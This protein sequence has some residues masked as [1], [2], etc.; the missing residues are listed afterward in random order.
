MNEFAQSQREHKSDTIRTSPR[1]ESNAMARRD[2]QDGLSNQI[3]Q[4]RAQTYPVFPGRCSFGGACHTCP[5][6]VQAKLTINEPGDKYEQEADRVADQ[7]MRMPDPGEGSVVSH[8]SPMIQRTCASCEEELQRQVEPEEEEE[9]LQTKPLADQITPLVQRQVEPEEEEEEPIQTKAAPKRTPTVT[10]DIQAQ[11]N[12]FRGRGRPLSA[13]TRAFFDQR[14]GRDFSHVRIHDDEQAAITTR[15]IQARAFTLGHNVVFG[16]GQYAPENVAGRRLLAHELAHVVQQRNRISGKTAQNSGQI[17][18]QASQPII[19]RN[20]SWTSLPKAARKTL[21]HSFKTRRAKPEEWIWW[22]GATACQCFNRLRSDRQSA[23]QSV[24]NALTAEGMWPEVLRVKDFWPRP[25]RGIKFVADSSKRL[26][27]KLIASHKFCEDTR[28][29]G[30]QHGGVMWRQVVAAGSEGLHIGVRANGLAGAHLDTIAPVAGRE[31]NG[32][33]R[34][35]MRHLL[36][37]I[38]RELWGWRYLE[39]FP[40]PTGKFRRGD[41]QPWLRIY[42]PGT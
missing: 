32:Q 40:V 36:P 1:T 37:H 21:Q 18:R 27:S 7:V 15:S 33:C 16:A 22:K 13:S 9:T 34:Y 41:V 42:I 25:V 24:Y 11:I 19:N 38:S 23:F 14:F 28:I 3:V 2:I 10:P 39:L 31:S 20:S 12:T 29:G 26:M 17:M 6:W 8:Q 5:A 4:Q 35:S 30:S